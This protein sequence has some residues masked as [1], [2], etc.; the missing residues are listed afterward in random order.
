MGDTSG[1]DQD[2]GAGIDADG[3]MPRLASAPMDAGND[4]AGGAGQQLGWP[5]AGT[6]KVV[7]TAP[8]PRLRA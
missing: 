7:H 3:V 8:M 6:V 5:A 2:A 4:Q 1:S